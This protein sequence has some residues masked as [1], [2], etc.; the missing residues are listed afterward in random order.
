M[1]FSIHIKC[2][3][4]CQSYFIVTSEHNG[5][6]EL[7]YYWVYGNKQEWQSDGR[8]NFRCLFIDLIFFYFTQPESVPYRFQ[9]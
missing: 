3:L 2:M 7:S 6:N 4:P 1:L 8:L 9:N 5:K